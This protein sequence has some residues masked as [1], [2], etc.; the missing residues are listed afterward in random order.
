[1]NLFDKLVKDAIEDTTFIDIDRA[2]FESETIFGL[3]FQESEAFLCLKRFNEHGE[4]DGVV[5]IRKDDV[6]FIGIG[7]NRRSATE[8]LVV[9]GKELDLELIINL[10]SIRTV[11]E[12]ISSKFGYVALYEE[13]YSEDF[14]IGEVLE[15]DDEFL[16]LHEYGTRKALDRSKILLRLDSITRIDADGKYEK[17]IIRTFSKRV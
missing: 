6:S 4:Y 16:L 10:T 9:E 13:E 15:I 17:S 11:I 3:I 1:M 2:G 5:V 7:G 12:S 14:Y 8:E